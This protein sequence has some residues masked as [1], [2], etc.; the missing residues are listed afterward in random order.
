M[1]LE[2]LAHYR[3][4]YPDVLA[5][6]P[7]AGGVLARRH[8]RPDV[9]AAMERW[10]Y[11]VLRYSRRDQLSLLAA[12]SDSSVSPVLVDLDIQSNLY[13]QWPASTGRDPD[14]QSIVRV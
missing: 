7:A 3:L 8:R 10:W 4:N 1:C 6:R 11:H 9:I 5:L 14:A 13:W 12:L 2:Q